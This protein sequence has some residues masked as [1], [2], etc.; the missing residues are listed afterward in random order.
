VSPL[1]GRLVDR[2]GARL[3]VQFSLAAGAAL[4]VALATS[5]RPLAYVPLIVAAAGSYGILFTP[6]FALI[7]E[8]AE[9]SRLPQG[10]AFGLMNAA[11]AIG[12]LLGPAA[13]GAVA[14]AAG[15]TLPFL[16]AAAI[17]AGALVA[18][19]RSRTRA[20]AAVAD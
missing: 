5:P 9:A 4:S 8:G 16:V 7:A 13:G 1:V 10:M 12:A 11:W 19:R 2:R 15:D 17:C 20:V 14:A 18:V 3:P 6:A